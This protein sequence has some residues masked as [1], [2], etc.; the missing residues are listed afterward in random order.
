MRRCA[1][2]GVT[3]DPVVE[4][5]VHLA[6]D[7]KRVGA[8]R[9]LALGTLHC[10]LAHATYRAVT[11]VVHR[12]PGRQA[13]SRSNAIAN[14]EATYAPLDEAS[15]FSDVDA[16]M[17]AVSTVNAYV[18]GALRNEA[19]GLRAEHESGMDPAEGQAAWWPYLQRLISAGCFPMMG[20]V[21]SEAPSVC[22]LSSNVV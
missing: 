10:R 13:A 1:S 20:Y 16:I 3:L 14:L 4:T 15:V 22:R 21:V 17:P 8:S 11:S 18:L 2:I 7:F 6:E 9:R 12:T 5:T 19:N